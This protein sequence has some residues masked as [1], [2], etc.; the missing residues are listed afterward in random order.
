MGH[1]LLVQQKSRGER[2]WGGG[3]RER[4]GE[5][6]STYLFRLR[7]SNYRLKL[8]M[9]CADAELKSPALKAAGLVR[10]RKQL[11]TTEWIQLPARLSGKRS[12]REP[13]VECGWALRVSFSFSTCS[14]PEGGR[15]AP[16]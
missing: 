13:H 2:V 8:Q 5:R 7:L 10:E 4:E 9:R 3:E 15:L 11:P 6:R 1:L 16:H 14:K 12:L